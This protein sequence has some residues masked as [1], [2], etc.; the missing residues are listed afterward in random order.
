MVIGVDMSGS[1]G[2]SV[3]KVFFARWVSIALCA[4]RVLFMALVGYLLLCLLTCALFI[5]FL[6]VTLCFVC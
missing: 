6:L 1:I 2:G 5:S 4:E 3:M